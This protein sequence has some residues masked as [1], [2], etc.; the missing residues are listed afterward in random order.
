L[1]NVA[2]NRA[3]DEQG[4]RASRGKGIPIVV[5]RAVRS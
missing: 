3:G 1:I 2:T 5:S 4:A